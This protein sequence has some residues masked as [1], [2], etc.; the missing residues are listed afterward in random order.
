MNQNAEIFLEKYRD[1][2][3]CIR[4]KYHLDHW[5]SAISY[6]EKHAEFR[7]VSNEL[8]FCRE[9]RN[10]LSH[11]PKIKE[12]Y[13]VEPSDEM[14]A[15]ID[16]VKE[17]LEKPPVIMDI[18]LPVKRL[19]YKSYDD[20]VVDTLREMN[21][22]SFGNVPILEKGVVAGVLSE[23]AIVNYIVRENTFQI[24]DELRLFDIQD[25]LLLERQKKEMY[26]FVKKDALISEVSDI[27]HNA[28]RKGVRVGMIFVTRNGR[29][30]E[31]LLGIATAWDLAGRK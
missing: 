11:K 18:A 31:K 2:E 21:D 15:L 19:L 30:D 9:V 22:R 3:Y 25:H 1:V 24:S 10:L 27:F 14:I 4:N 13:C 26:Q 29:P 23:K 6:L 20:N 28:L 12:E 7:D 8:K 17:I 5:E 16:H